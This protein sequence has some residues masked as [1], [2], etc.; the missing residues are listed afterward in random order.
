[1]NDRATTDVEYEEAVIAELS[2][3]IK[4]EKELRRILLSA[5]LGLRKGVYNNIL[6]HLTFKPR[7]FRKLMR[8]A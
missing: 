5:T 3:K 6:P 2:S 8:D 4:D 1:M 7:S